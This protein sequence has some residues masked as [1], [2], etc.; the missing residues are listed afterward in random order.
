MSNINYGT[1]YNFF[2]NNSIVVEKKIL[3]EST[4]FDTFSTQLT[5][6]QKLQV[7]AAVKSRIIP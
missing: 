5:L 2:F 1:K 6:S 3:D 7:F 4:C